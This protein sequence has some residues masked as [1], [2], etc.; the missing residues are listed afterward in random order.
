[1]GKHGGKLPWDIYFNFCQPV[2]APYPQCQGAAACQS[3][4]EA[5][6]RESKSLGSSTS[7]T[8]TDINNGVKYTAL[9]GTEQ[10]QFELSI[11]CAPE[12]ESEPYPTFVHE[13]EGLLY[14]QFSWNHHVAC[15]TGCEGGF[16][17]PSGGW[18]GGSIFLL[19]LFL[20][21]VI[22]LLVGVLFLRFAKDKRGIEMIPNKDFWMDFPN[23]VKDGFRFS[24]AK[25]K[26]EEYTAI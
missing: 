25:I 22:Y 20:M 16:E 9:G 8:F 10:R 19:I 5:L 1:M 13:Q 6:G 26:R 14:Y 24:I 18:D 11:H 12:S 3:W 17:L 4:M 2:K 23:L 21:A 15:G 7:G